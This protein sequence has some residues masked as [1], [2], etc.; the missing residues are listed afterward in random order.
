MD[1]QMLQA[2][3][4]ALTE[5][6]NL[7]K[8]HNQLLQRL[9]DHQTQAKSKTGFDVDKEEF[10]LVSPQRCGDNNNN[11]LTVNGQI[12]G[13]KS[14][15]GYFKGVS[16]DASVY[17]DTILG[18]GRY[19]MLFIDLEV[20]GNNAIPIKLKVGR[21]NRPAN[22]TKVM[23]LALL[24][25]IE[26]GQLL[27]F[28][29]EPADRRSLVVLCNIYCDGEQL[30]SKF[31]DKHLPENEDKE[32]A[33]IWS[34]IWDEVIRK[35]GVTVN[36]KMSKENQETYGNP[37]PTEPQVAEPQVA[38][39]QVAQLQ[40]GQSVSDED[41]LKGSI[42]KKV[43]T[44]TGG[45]IPRVKELLNEIKPSDDGSQSKL[46]SLNMPE[47][48]TLAVRL[49]WDWYYANALG[50][51]Q[52]QSR[53]YNELLKKIAYYKTYLHGQP[54]DEVWNAMPD[55]LKQTIDDE[56]LAADKTR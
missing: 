13:Y 36:E 18:Q 37:Q 50:A 28:E 11:V 56:K 26:P 19:E 27:R 25:G 52:D 1:S 43:R 8:E 48:E 42:V 54:L 6:N 40:P 38:E 5:N 24:D 22:H 14:V 29:F 53:A 17:K 33:E 44:K 2:L 31:P 55:F 3:I 23:L 7:K 35:Y 10:T 41:A 32:K 30:Y 45:T 4:N 16:A 20:T 51:K 39:P 49:L 21:S 12:S 15:T 34:S 9:V 47:V 46:I